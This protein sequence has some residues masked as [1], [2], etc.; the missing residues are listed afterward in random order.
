MA[1]RHCR[2][3]NTLHMFHSSSLVLSH[4]KRVAI[5]ILYSRPHIVIFSD[6]RRWRSVHF[7]QYGISKEL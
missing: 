6:F 7:E 2:F 1:F 4:T 5:K 3:Y